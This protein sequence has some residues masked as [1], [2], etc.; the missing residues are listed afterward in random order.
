[1]LRKLLAALAAL[2][3]TTGLTLAYTSG[4]DARSVLPAEGN[5]AGVD[6]SGRMVTLSFGGNYMSHF[7]VG[8]KVIGGAHVSKGAWHETCHG[9]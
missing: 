8:H 3:V 4:A 6:H 7:T 5:Y 9:G 1:M 2:I